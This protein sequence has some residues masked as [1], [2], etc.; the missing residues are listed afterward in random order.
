MSFSGLRIPV[1]QEY[2]RKTLEAVQK[3]DDDL[4]KD[5]IESGELEGIIGSRE[6]ML[7][8]QFLDEVWIPMA[9]GTNPLYVD[10]IEELLMRCHPKDLLISHLVKYISDRIP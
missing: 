6:G 4:F 5:M 7:P 3:L 8:V 2:N 9:N 10:Q 1:L